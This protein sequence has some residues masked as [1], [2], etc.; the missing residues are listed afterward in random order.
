MNDTMMKPTASLSLDLDN[1]WAY[2]R[3]H[4]SKDWENYPSYLGLV[5]PRILEWC[6]DRD[7]RLTCFVVGRDA[8]RH[9]NRDVLAELASA[10][11]E[12]GNHSLN[13]YPWM[14]TLPREQ[15]EIEIREAED[16]IESAT[17]QVPIGFRGPGFSYSN[18]VLSVLAECGYMYDATTLPTCLGPLARW[19]FRHTASREAADQADR[20][21]LF[22][23]LGDCLRP[24]RPYIW[25]TTS[26]PLVEMPVTTMPLCRL[27]IHMTY[28]VYLARY[29][30]RLAKSYFRL[31]ITACRAFGVGPS[32]LLHPL[33]FLGAEDDPDLRFFPGMTIPLAQKRELVSSVFGMVARHF[34]VQPMNV[35]A[36]QL[37]PAQRKL[38]VATAA[39]PELA[40]T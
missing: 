4:G 37:F 31:A 15:V 9:E 27:P 40:A 26:G 21:Q 2:L 8:Q 12:I 16:A 34:D 32:L 22:G 5:V 36:G 1:K 39:V 19:Y 38:R 24:I 28:L 14:H 17:G 20:R 6:S 7:L 29:S 13:H 11:H 18:D 23:S 25:E 33:D 35:H 3:T 30:P 10:G